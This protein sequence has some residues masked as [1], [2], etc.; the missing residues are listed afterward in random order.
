[1][2]C[3][4]FSGFKAWE[5]LQLIMH[6]AQ[7]RF[8]G[9]AKIKTGTDKGIKEVS[10]KNMSRLLRKGGR[11]Y[12]LHIEKV[13][14]T[15]VNGNGKMHPDISII[16]HNYTSVLNDPH[17]LP[18]KRDFDHYIPLKDEAHPINVHPYCYAHFQKEEI[19]RQIQEM[20][21]KGL[22]RPSSSPFSSLVLLVKK[23]DG[24]WRFCTDY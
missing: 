12:A 17:E 14:D 4:G 16:L 3:L 21:E 9:R 24:T 15:T 7:W 2:L 8:Y 5:R 11:C 20:L 18:P 23:K 1:M 13:E 22:I 10:A 6:K 19:E